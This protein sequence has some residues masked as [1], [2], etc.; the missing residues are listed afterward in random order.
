MK[1]RGLSYQSGIFFIGKRF[2][3]CGYH[4][5]NRLKSWVRPL[6]GK[7]LIV[8]LMQ[9]LRATPLSFKILALLVFLLVFLPKSLATSW[10]G[11]PYYTIFYFLFGTHFLFPRELKKYHG[12]EH[13]VF[14]ERG[15]I[16]RSRLADIQRAAIT[17]RYCSTNVVVTYFL[18][19]LVLFLVF[20]SFGMKE[21]A[22]PIASYSSL[23]TT[24]LVSPLMNVNGFGWL[25][26]IILS[27][28]YFCQKHITTTEPDRKHLL[29]AIDGYRKLAEKEFPDH[30]KSR[31]EEKK[32]A[33]ADVTVIPIGTES[34]S[35]S[36]YVASIHSVLRSYEG[37]IKYELTPMSTIIEAEL[38]VLFEVIEKIHE[39]PFANGAK[40]V[41]TNIRI[42]DRRD[43]VVTMEGKIESV[44]KKLTEGTETK[45]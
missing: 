44:Q 12:A 45:T 27:I 1:I 19:V 42:D 4:E 25:K 37:K 28:S 13:K 5:D 3:S 29:A 38:P 32:L 14:S 40:R 9:M 11:L 31:K 34:T 36:E 8:M 7:T 17:N 20:I 39:V 6:D 33:I 41:A 16:L 35:L 24:M 43:Q 10:E 26:K 2:V 21:T 18:S 23:I 22:L 30:E 15:P